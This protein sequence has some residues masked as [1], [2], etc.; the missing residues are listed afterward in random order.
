MGSLVYGNSSIEVAFD[1]RALMHL[2][3]VITNKLRRGESFVLTWVNA[4]ELGSGR[5]TIWLSPSSTLFYRYSGSR[6]PTINREWI[7]VLM[8][9]ANSASGLFFSP[10]PRAP[11]AA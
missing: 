1:D 10:E 2:Q 4:P 3:I 7:E 9:S 6:I 5:S 11:G 8:L